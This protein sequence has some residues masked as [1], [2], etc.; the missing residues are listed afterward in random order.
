[1]PTTNWDSLSFESS[2]AQKKARDKSLFGSEVL[3]YHERDRP[4]SRLGGAWDLQTSLV[5]G[6][7]QFSEPRI[8]LRSALDMFVTVK[9]QST[10]DSDRSIPLL[11]FFF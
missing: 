8:Q 1:M 4:S 3:A 5:G 11:V 2:S 10:L 9:I 7:C 6:K